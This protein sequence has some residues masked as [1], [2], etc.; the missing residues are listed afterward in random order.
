MQEW[1]GIQPLVCGDEV[2]E[3]SVRRLYRHTRRKKEDH[4]FVYHKTCRGSEKIKVEKHPSP[5][6]TPYSLP[7]PQQ[8]PLPY[9]PILPSKNLGAGP[10]ASSA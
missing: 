7:S 3:E 10:A 5:S 6:P 1:E 4:E 2:G 9:C 8:P